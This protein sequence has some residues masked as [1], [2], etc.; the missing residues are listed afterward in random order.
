MTE[1][2]F[3]I[4]KI[5]VAA[6]AGALAAWAREAIIGYCRRAKLEVNGCDFHDGGTW[7][8]FYIIVKNFGKTTA[9]ACVGQLTI[10]PLKP[11]KVKSSGLVN[12]NT[13]RAGSSASLDNIST[14]WARAD[15]P[16]EIAIH[17]GQA[18]RLVI[19]RARS[20]SPRESSD[21]TIPTV[22]GYKP[23]QIVFSGAGFEY[24]VS[25]GSDNAD[26]I[27]AFGRVLWSELGPTIELSD[28]ITQ[29]FQ[30]PPIPSLWRRKFKFKYR[31]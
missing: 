1:P 24:L 28:E 31:R 14:Y 27:F 11:F 6:S 30:L 7:R 25:I 19:A 18:Q 8:E 3:T 12:E 15:K 26:P 5:L 22:F 20:R 2:Y 17:P 9:R 4:I 13:I 16:M 29:A 21:F 10:A 23:P